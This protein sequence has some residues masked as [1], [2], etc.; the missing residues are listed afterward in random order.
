MLGALVAEVEHMVALLHSS[1]N[2]HAVSEM[3]CVCLSTT[4]LGM[5]TIPAAAKGVLCLLMMQAS[6]LLVP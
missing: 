1:D 4:A 5:F 3:H 2:S 6:T